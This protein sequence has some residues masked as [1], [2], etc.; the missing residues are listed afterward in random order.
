MRGYSLVADICRAGLLHVGVCGTFYL[1]HVTSSSLF[2][3]FSPR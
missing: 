1:H 2:V 3:V